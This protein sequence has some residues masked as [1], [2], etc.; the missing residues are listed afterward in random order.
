MTQPDRPAVRPRHPPGAVIRAVNPLVRR[1]SAHGLMVGSILVLHFVG[2]RSGQRYDVPAGYHLIDGVPTVFTNSGWRHN[3]AD[4]PTVEVTYRGARR[5]T[6]AE[7]VTDVDQVAEVYTALI[8]RLGWRRS[9]RRLG[10]RITVGRMPTR[11][12]V[13]A[14]VTESGLSMVRLPGPSR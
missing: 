10:I 4:A 13:A 6:R 9:Q 7:L 2:R 14:S 5:T 11:A 3:F 8:E 1:L 12:E